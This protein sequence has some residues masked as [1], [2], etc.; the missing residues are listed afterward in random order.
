MREM[1]KENADRPPYGKHRTGRTC[2]DCQVPVGEKKQLCA[3][4]RAEHRRHVR[5][6][7]PCTACGRLRKSVSDVCMACHSEQRRTLVPCPR[8]HADFWP[9]ADGVGHARKY[10]SKACLRK[11]MVPK[12]RAPK[13]SK[14][15]IHC[16][17]PYVAFR[18]DQQCCSKPC[19]ERYNSK[20]RKA[21][22]K[23]LK[24]S[25]ITAAHLFK[26]GDSL[27]ALCQG[28]VDR[29]LR[30]PHP[31]SATVDHI[32]PITKGG[33]HSMDNVQLAHARC[34]LLKGNRVAA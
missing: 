29:A 19:R 18:R 27:C 15:C 20:L 23:G 33:E 21:R 13:V 9:W 12:A 32:H 6:A 17:Q 28:V 8:C 11:P 25:V 24:P 7:T 10:C 2:R 26:R 3:A 31:L 16:L 34:N 4:C 14:E 1:P 5:D 22:L 30:Y